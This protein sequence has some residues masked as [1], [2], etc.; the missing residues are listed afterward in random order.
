VGGADDG[1]TIIYRFGPIADVVGQIKSFER[2][3]DSSLTDLYGQFTKLFEADWQGQAGAACD[4]ARQKWNRG[5]DEIK[6]ALGL[7]GVRL[8]QGAEDV[9]ALDG[10]LAAKVRSWE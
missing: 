5:A 1:V 6:M 8:S 9:H 3:M 7:L 4:E 10:H 2:I